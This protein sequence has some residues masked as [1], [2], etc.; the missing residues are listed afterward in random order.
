MALSDYEHIEEARA[1]AS[2]VGEIKDIVKGGLDPLDILPLISNISGIIGIVQPVLAEETQAEA[3]VKFALISG[4]VYA[5]REARALPDGLKKANILQ[6]VASAAAFL[7]IN[8]PD[9]A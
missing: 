5:M 9:E 1:L 2:K 8:L 4:L 6:A 3:E 7:E